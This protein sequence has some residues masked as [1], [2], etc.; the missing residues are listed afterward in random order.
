MEFRPCI[1]IHNGK[2]KQIVGGSLKDEANDAVENFVSGQDAAFYARL[3][4]KEEIRGGHVILLNAKDSEYYDATRQQALLALREYPGG[5]QVGG[6]ITA[7]NAKEF[8]D[9]GA[10]H[11]I[12][13]SYVFRDGKI[14]YELLEE[15]VKT[16]GREHLV[17]DLSCRKRN[18][19]YYIVTDRW[20][21]FTSEEVTVSLLNRLKDSCDEFLIHAV[22]V[23]GKAG[24]IEE[25]L[26]ELLG[27]WGKI[28]V[29]Y[30]GG[31]GSFADLEKLKRIGKNKLNVTIGSALDLFGGPMAYDKVLEYVNKEC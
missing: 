20:Q 13:T 30:A 16:V 31:V 18:G 12:V 15:L 24:G 3:Y 7:E 4:K 6:G 22:D 21:K 19:K 2:V 8:L 1:D 29:T 14:R 27:N 26:A 11:V 5:L 9:A 25:E 10:S 17:L 28:P 23:E